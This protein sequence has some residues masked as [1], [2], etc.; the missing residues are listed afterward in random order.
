[1]HKKKKR[2][3][4]FPGNIIVSGR[5]AVAASIEAG[6]VEHL[7]VSYKRKGD[8][9][10][11]LAALKGVEAGYLEEDKLGDLCHSSN[12]QGFVAVCRYVAPLSLEAILGRLKGKKDPLLI[13][14]DGIEDP[15]NLGSLLRSAD[16]L[17]ADALIT[18]ERG[19]APLTEAAAKVS[20][21]AFNYVPIVTVPNLTGCIRTLKENGYWIVATDAKAKTD[22]DEVDYSGKMAIVIGSEGFGISRLVKE[23]SDFIVKIPLV[24]HVNSLNAAVAGALFM[25]VATL[26]R[27]ESK[28]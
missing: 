20:T 3:R 8:R 12:H 19:Q 7:F 21:G 28:R 11:E 1:M 24:G 22:Y 10:L 25:A 5:N 13:I 9:L 26:K 4:P 15:V 27:N 6:S 23:N 17:G 16:A 18:K 14:L 2:E